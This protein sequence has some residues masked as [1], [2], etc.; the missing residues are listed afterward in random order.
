[1]EPVY[2]QYRD[3]ILM[4]ARLIKRSADCFDHAVRL[5][6]ERLQAFLCQDN[7]FIHSNI[8]NILVY[9]VGFAAVW[10]AD[11]SPIVFNGQG[12]SGPPGR[13]PWTLVGHC[14]AHNFSAGSIGNCRY[15][16]FTSSSG[17]AIRVNRV[18]WMHYYSFDYGLYQKRRKEIEEAEIWK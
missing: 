15:H 4:R 17:L 12:S 7:S 3:V 18:H 2:E 8:W 11:P 6:A 16:S 9:T 13:L 10:Q 1:M 5:A 14:S